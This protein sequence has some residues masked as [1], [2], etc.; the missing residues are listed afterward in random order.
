[1]TRLTSPNTGWLP[2]VML[3]SMVFKCFHSSSVIAHAA[4]VR[5]CSLDGATH[6]H[7]TLGGER[8]TFFDHVQVSHKDGSQH[9]NEQ[10]PVG[11]IVSFGQLAVVGGRWSWVEGVGEGVHKLVGVAPM[12]LAA[13]STWL[14]EVLR[15]VQHISHVVQV[16]RRYRPR[17]LSFCFH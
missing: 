1:M 8:R 14:H 16:L 3:C 9:N 17:Y 2:L 15:V 6:T 13:S 12:S 11:C 7:T 10:P 5:C 4:L